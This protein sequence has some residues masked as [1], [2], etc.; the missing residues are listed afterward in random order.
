MTDAVRPGINTMTEK[1]DQGGLL[2][3][4]KKI[5]RY[6]SFIIVVLVIVLIGLLVVVYHLANRKE[7]VVITPAVQRTIVV[8][9][10]YMISHPFAE[11][12]SRRIV[13]L[14][15]NWNF[16]NLRYNHEELKKLYYSPELISS[17]EHNAESD[18]LY[19]LVK[20][21]KMASYFDIDFKKSEISQCKKI[22]RICAYIVGRRHLMVNGNRPLDEREVAYF[23]MGKVVNPT[24]NPSQMA[25]ITTRV[26][27]FDRDNDRIS[28]AKELYEIAKSGV[29]PKRRR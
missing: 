22:Q 13:D 17:L 29:I 23:I 19:E 2:Y 6:Y 1:L 24:T 7:R 25:I 18:N 21:K 11:A 10:D 8:D 26:D 14:S 15:E 27:V 16:Q 12:F 4:E 28:D 20:E 5:N 9:E 3:L